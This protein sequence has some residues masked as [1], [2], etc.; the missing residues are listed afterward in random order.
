MSP[1]HSPSVP[2]FQIRRRHVSP[3]TAGLFPECPDAI[4][5]KQVVQSLAQTGDQY[6]ADSNRP[7]PDCPPAP[8]TSHGSQNSVEGPIRIGVANYS[9][10]ASARLVGIARLAAS[11]PPAETRR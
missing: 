1:V 6:N 2:R 8:L 11:S 7:A 9:E 5:P 10:R 4:S 3:T